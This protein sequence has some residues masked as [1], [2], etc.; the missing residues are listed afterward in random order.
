MMALITRELK[1]PFLLLAFT[2]N[3]INRQFREH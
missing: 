1:A 3:R 2:F